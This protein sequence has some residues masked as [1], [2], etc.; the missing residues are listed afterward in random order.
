M[1]IVL[2]QNNALTAIPEKMDNSFLAGYKELATIYRLQGKEGQYQS[3]LQRVVLFANRISIAKEPEHIQEEKFQVNIIAK[4]DL[5]RQYAIFQIHVALF[6]FIAHEELLKARQL[7]T[8]AEENC[9]MPDEYITQITIRF[10]EI[11]RGYLWRGY[12]L[13]SLGRYDEAYDSLVRVTPIYQNYAKSGGEISDIVEYALTKAIIPLCEFKLNPSKENLK[14]AQKGIED[15][16]ISIH[17]PLFKL[18]GYPYYFHLKEQF[19]DVY[20]TNPKTFLSSAGSQKK[21]S[22]KPPALPNA[23]PAI[24]VEE[25]ALVIWDPEETN[26]FE[27]LG[28]NT[29]FIRFIDYV[30]ALGGYPDLVGLIDIYTMGEPHKAKPYADDCRR[31]VSAKGIDPA[32]LK[33]GKKLCKAV[34]EAAAGDSLIQIYQDSELNPDSTE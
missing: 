16:I 21:S 25:G 14:K 31:F 33:V 22:A 9:I 8:W 17:N 10:D 19:S 13:L 26:A 29:D 23:I 2:A 6:F 27:I 4:T 30:K 20:A 34:Q 5:L 3:M 1:E 18:R 15:Y 28:R 12:A 11:A 32:M 24:P 7:F